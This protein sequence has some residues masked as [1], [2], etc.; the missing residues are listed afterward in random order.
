MKIVI[1][2]QNIGNNLFL[3]SNFFFGLV[4]TSLFIGNCANISLCKYL[5]HR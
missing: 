1:T 2:E 5:I 3:T 4:V